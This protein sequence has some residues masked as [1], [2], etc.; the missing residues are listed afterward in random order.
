MSGGTSQPNLNTLVEALR[1]SSRE[2]TLNSE[3]LDKLAEY[4]YAVREFYKPFE[5][6]SVPATSGLYRHEMPGGQYTNLYQQAKAL[7]LSDRWDEVC[8]VYAEVNQ[9]FGDI[10]KVTPTSKSVGDMALFMVANN[11]KPSDVVNSDRELAY[12]ESVVDLIG[13]KMGQPPGGFP[14]AVKQRILRGQPGLTER[15]G[16][17]L[18]PVDIAAARREVETFLERQGRI[19]PTSNLEEGTFLDRE[20]MSYLMYDKV[21]C[22]FAIHQIQ[23]SDTSVLPTPAFFFGQEPGEEI[24]VE[25]ESG[26]TLIIKYLTQGE[27]RPD[28][29]QTVF[30]ELNGQPREVT[31]VNRKLEP[32]AQKNSKADSANPKQ[33]GAAMPGMVVA[34]AVLIGDAVKKGQKLFTLEAMKMESTIYAEVDGVVGQVLVTPGKQVQTGDLLLTYK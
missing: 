10:V 15:P 1:F 11:L 28:G 31:V 22:D 29:T 21:Y 6:E 20:T 30:F 13:G 27:T 5:S 32:T 19:K 33:V 16:A 14:E 26:K 24:S 9:M 18:P 8:S 12:P 17:T 23:F 7:G 3:R 2:T 4:W 25:I 34:V